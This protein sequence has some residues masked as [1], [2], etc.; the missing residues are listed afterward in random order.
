MIALICEYIVGIEIIIVGVNILWLKL[1]K[2]EPRQSDIS[3][4]TFSSKEEY[5]QHI[6]DM[7][8]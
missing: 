8:K 3:Y 6:K 4:K 1:G 2:D 7:C 5:A